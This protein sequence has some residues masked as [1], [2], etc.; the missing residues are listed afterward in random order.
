MR[1]DRRIITR[2][3]YGMI[4]LILILA[5]FLIEFARLLGWLSV[6]S[7]RAM[8]AAGYLLLAMMF[9]ANGHNRRVYLKYESELSLV[10]KSCLVNLIT[11][12]F[13]AAAEDIPPETL[14]FGIVM[15]TVANLASIVIISLGVNGFSRFKQLH[16]NKIWHVYGEED[17]RNVK[18]IEEK[19]SKCDE[20]YLHGLPSSHRSIFMQLCFKLGKTVYYTA[21]LPDVMLKSSG[22]AQDHDMPV[23]YCTNFGIG[24]TSAFLKRA[25]DIVASLLLLVILSPL[26]LATAAM[27]KLEDGGKAIYKQARCTKDMKIFQIYKFRSMQEESEKQQAHLAMEDQERITRIGRWIRRYKIDELPQLVNILKGDMSFVGPRPEQPELIEKALDE[28]PAFSL[29]TKVKAGLTGYAQVRGRYDTKFK[30]KLLW[31]LIYI[32]N[33][34]LM[35][36]VKILIMTVFKVISGK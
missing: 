24:S 32:E 31:D 20:V 28:T 22:L 13:I 3:R 9:L 25:F 15:L 17:I 18:K 1:T 16:I 34:S 19:I 30:D 14:W 27:I 23:Y 12:F 36:D 35:L 33:F 2:R 7:D 10:I 6:R 5:V 21:E 8:L 26:F 29:R 4:K 11:G